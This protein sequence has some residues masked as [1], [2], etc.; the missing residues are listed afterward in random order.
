MLDAQLETRPV[1]WAVIPAGGR[2][3]RM[4]P[5]SRAVP[6][7][8]LPIGTRPMIQYSLQEA[9]CA[10]LANVAIVINEDKRAI[11][12]YFESL[13][14][15]GQFS[16]CRIEYL[17]QPRP[18]GLADAISMCREH[19]EGE[20][21]ALLLPDN[22]AITR[23]NYLKRMVHL[24]S[25]LGRDVVGVMKLSSSQSGMFGNA[26][27]ID[28]HNQADGTIEITK[29]Y[30]KGKGTIRI[31]PGRELLRTCGRYIFHSD[32]FRFVDRVRPT[33]AGEF[34]EVPVVQSII[35]A[36]GFLGCQMP[37]PLFDV[38]NERGFLAANS[39]LFGELPCD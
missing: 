26:G 34:D 24:H 10:G 11:R 36:R 16:G 3:T 18:L 19:I 27:R 37:W 2:G 29:M 6:K 31:E 4:H 8:L 14:A 38:G 20:A 39:H 30:D 13:Q 33:V 21:F 17:N 15:E 28:C 12:E 35:A 23:E 5:V 1:S 22:V 25:R 9:E 32:F 7:E